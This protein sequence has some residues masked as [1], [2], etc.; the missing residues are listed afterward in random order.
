MK[1]VFSPEIVCR[2][3]LPSDRTDVLEFTKFIWDGH[4]YIQYVW[5]DWL[6]DPCG[7]MAVAVYGGHAVALGKASCVAED[8][9][10]LE[11]LRVDPK[12]QGLKISSHMFEYL[13]DWWKRNAGGA[14]R[15]MT[16]SQR[17]QVHHLCARLGYDKLG[18]VKA[19][20]A[21]PLAGEPHGFQQF[22]STDV[23]DALRFVSKHLGY[24]YGLADFGWKFAVPDRARFE[25]MSRDGRLW[26]AENGLVGYWDDED[27]GQ[28]TMGL[29][30][31]ACDRSAIAALLRDVRRLA[32]EL[33]F[34]SVLWHAPVEDDVL[35]AAEHAGY[36]SEYPGSAYVFGKSK[37]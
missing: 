31:A 3:A 10:W 4:D 8:Q 36:A 9:W 34:S 5:D 23:D 16:S 7:L 6:A 30:F 14:I 32:A 25:E 35:R 13:D 22:T 19:Y 26:Q 20:V 37:D 24:C 28:R 18:E 2:P 29:A 21:S 1:H 11:G 27:D 33:G 15:L 17:V 12:Y